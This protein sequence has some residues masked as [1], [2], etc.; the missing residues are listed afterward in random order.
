MLRGMT[1]WLGLCITV[2]L[3]GCGGGSSADAGPADVGPRDAAV[4]LDATINDGGLPGADGGIDAG[5]A[6][7]GPG[8]AGPGDAGP[9]AEF[10]VVLDTLVSEFSDHPLSVTPAG[11]NT[12]GLFHYDLPSG[13]LADPETRVFWYVDYHISGI[14]PSAYFSAYWYALAPDGA[15]WFDVANDLFDDGPARLVRDTIQ[16]ESGATPRELISAPYGG[17]EWAPI[18]SGVNVFDITE[19]SCSQ[20]EDRLPTEVMSD[21]RGRYESSFR[22]A[23][24]LSVVY[25][26][27][28]YLGRRRCVDRP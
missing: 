15:C 10:E 16:D 23:S 26:A 2:V 27:R 3:A 11:T 17:G 1:R 6:D 24:G 13:A 5:P 19:I 9:C 20:C 7:A 4:T 18:G 12:V 8:D 14:S 21:D 25:D 28:I 22:A